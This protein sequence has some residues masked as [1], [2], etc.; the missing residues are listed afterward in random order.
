MGKPAY[1]LSYVDL[2]KH[3][4]CYSSMEFN[5]SH[6]TFFF[7][8][9][10]LS[11]QHHLFPH[12]SGNLSRKDI[13]RISNSTFYNSLFLKK[14]L[15]FSGSQRKHFL[16]VK[17]LKHGLQC[18]LCRKSLVIN[19]Y[20][21]LYVPRLVHSKKLSILKHLQFNNLF[22]LNLDYGFK[23]E[24]TKRNHGHITPDSS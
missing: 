15:Y 4:L 7:I 20:R 8:N 24:S 18:Y 19:L 11:N 6:A 2:C 13:S 1:C 22:E 3:N 17:F 12:G 14:N 10:L 5:V 23:M 21:Y 9:Y 16:N